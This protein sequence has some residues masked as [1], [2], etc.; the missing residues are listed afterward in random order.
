M[1]ISDA[2]ASVEI[3]LREMGPVGAPGEGDLGIDV[4]AT[5]GA[6][7]VG[8][9]FAGRNGSVWI[10]GDDWGR[11]L[12]ALR[13]LERTR[14]G[15]A[16]VEAMSPGEFRLVVIVTDRAGHVAAEGW[17]GRR[18]GARSSVVHDRVSFRVE[19][20]PTTLPLLVRQFEA[21]APAG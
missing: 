9:P 18:Y 3:S 6:T 2:T 21:I 10:R 20:E 16:G 19:L 12:Q 4:A 11:F 14:R 1:V 17:V 13:E 7:S 15:E 8:G 5:A